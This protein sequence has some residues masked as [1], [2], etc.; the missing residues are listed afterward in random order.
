VLVAT[1]TN[2]RIKLKAVAFG[3]GL[4]PIRLPKLSAAFDS[5]RKSSKSRADRNAF[6]SLVTIAKLPELLK[7]REEKDPGAG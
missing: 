2:R 3:G 4:R 6:R 1:G 5:G 7:P